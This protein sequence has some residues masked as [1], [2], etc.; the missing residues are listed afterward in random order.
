MVAES[1]LFGEILY[2]VFDCVVVVI[3]DFAVM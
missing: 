3:C 2:G 1:M